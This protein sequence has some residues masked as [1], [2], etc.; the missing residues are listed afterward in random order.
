MEPA[1]RNYYYSPSIAH[2]NTGNTWP[3]PHHHQFLAAQAQAAQPYLLLTQPVIIAGSP[4]TTASSPNQANTMT[5]V[6]HAQAAPMANATGPFQ[7]LSIFGTT[8][9]PQPSG[10]HQPSIISSQYA[11]YNST[12]AA[13][14]SASVFTGPTTTTYTD[15]PRQGN[16]V[17]DR[18][19]YL[20]DK[21]QPAALMNLRQSGSTHHYLQKPE[22]QAVALSTE[23][24]KKLELIEKQVDLSRDMDLIERHGIVITRS[25]DP[26][27]LM[28]YLTEATTR[29]Y[30][31]QFLPSDDY[32]I[33]F[34]EIIKRPGQ[35]LGLYIRT[36]Q[37][38]GSETRS[39]RDGLVIT[40]IESDS[41]IYDSQVLHVG[42]EILS[43][44]L[45]D[46]QGMSMD[47][48]VIIMSIP[49]RLVLALR[50][51][52]ERDQLLMAN[53]THQ[54]RLLKHS[55]HQDEMARNQFSR[56]VYPFGGANVSSIYNEESTTGGNKREGFL[57]NSSI[58]GDY[59]QQRPG[60]IG[61]DSTF[62]HARPIR[63][64]S[65][66]QMSEVVN[67][68][69]PGN[70][71]N[72]FD[73]DDFLRSPYVSNNTYRQ[74]PYPDCLASDGTKAGVISQ[75]Q[76]NEQRLI[77]H[78]DR[79]MAISRSIDDSR[80]ESERFQSFAIDPELATLERDAMNKERPGDGQSAVSDLEFD[81]N[82]A[83]SG[84]SNADDYCNNRTPSTLPRRTLPT[85]PDLVSPGP[86]S[87]TRQP[88]ISNIRLGNTPEQSSYFS[89]SIDAINRELKELR[90]QRMALSN[91]SSGLGS[92]Q[93][94]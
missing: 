53:L 59:Q 3:L 26:Y 14:V 44:N 31:T 39:P 70:N 50:I 28:P 30:R 54:Q 11:I 10:Q 2:M 73:G 88:I 77:G 37:L 38:D 45:V 78:I 7:A 21:Q 43:I 32:V 19:A 29:R 71:N 24:F 49:K 82:K 64:Q 65:A 93:E 1:P 74:L 25:V 61:P 87:S 72:N 57:V 13:A 33:R 81:G 91:E 47:D 35:T 52:R 4:A 23:I 85:R 63:V 75:K 36:V 69:L 76:H 89:S 40:K 41:P 42:D 94:F 22:R 55:V 5:L 48:V 67:E 58:G 18:S 60:S 15:S 80:D 86:T 46:V 51:P 84:S 83:K 17:R 79:Q 20:A 90:R 6:Q 56:Q 66:F 16:L 34:I 68:K 9:P 62:H 92:N 8:Q 27:S 12:A